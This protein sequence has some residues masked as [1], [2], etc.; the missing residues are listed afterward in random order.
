MNNSLTFNEGNNENYNVSSDVNNVNDINNI[1]SFFGVTLCILSSFIPPL[2]YHNIDP[3]KI[4][5]IIPWFSVFFIGMILS[6]I[7]NHNFIEIIEILEW[8][9][10]LSSIFLSGLLMNYISL[11]SFNTNEHCCENDK[12]IEDCCHNDNPDMHQIIEQNKKNNTKYNTKHWSYSILIGDSLCNFSDGLIITSSFIGCGYMSGFLI[13]IGVILHEITHEIG[14]FS[15]L[16]DSGISFKR[17]ILYN[18]L[19]SSVSYLGWL[20]TIILDS[21][22]FKDISLYLITFSSGM[23]GSVVI[24]ILPKMIKNKSLKIQN[25]RLF[26]LFLGMSLGTLM[27]SLLPHHCEDHSDHHGELVDNHYDDHDN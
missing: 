3:N 9:N 11:F 6:L 12:N 16:L 19:S 7:F 17:A 23:L 20:F 21:Y 25:L 10:K 13:L 1:I 18:F 4:N 22:K 8:D 15:L 26:I 5:D 14:D 27:F 2:I 24:S